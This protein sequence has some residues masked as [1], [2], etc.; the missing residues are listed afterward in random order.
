MRFHC[1]SLPRRS[2]AKSFYRK[3]LHY[4]PLPNW[5]RMSATHHL[6]ANGLNSV[7]TWGKPLALKKIACGRCGHHMECHICFIKASELSL[8]KQFVLSFRMKSKCKEN[9]VSGHVQNFVWTTTHLHRIHISVTHSKTCLS[10]KCIYPYPGFHIDSGHND[11]QIVKHSRQ[12]S[13][14]RLEAKPHNIHFYDYDSTP[15]DRLHG[16]YLHYFQ[17]KGTHQAGIHVMGHICLHQ[18]YILIFYVQLSYMCECMLFSPL[19]AAA[20]IRT[21]V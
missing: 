21:F 11:V 16:N 12:D 3:I 10:R 4:S 5:Y 19:S 15:G 7:G 8:V 20:R 13:N 2:K 18:K 14:D 1:L 9:W 6:L 17:S